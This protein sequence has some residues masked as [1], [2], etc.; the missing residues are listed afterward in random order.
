MLRTLKTKRAANAALL[1]QRG[2]VLA[3]RV[4]QHDGFVTV[5]TGRNDIDRR[6]N[7]LFDAL[8]VGA[9]GCRQ[10]FQGLGTQR[11]FAPARHLLVDRTQTQV[12]VGVSRCVDDRAFFVLVADADVDG[13]KTVKHVQLGQAQAR[14][15]VDFDG[16]TQDDGIEPAATT[17]ATGGSAELVA[18]LGQESTDIV[19]QLGRERTRTHTRG[20]GLG[21]AQNVIQ[22][23]RTKTRTGSDTASSGVGAGDVRISTV[24]D[25]Q[26]RTLGTFEHDVL[27]VATHF[28]QRSGDVEHQRL[29]QIGIFHAL[30]ECL[31]EV[32][33]RLFVVIDQHEVVVVE[34]LAQLGREAF[35]MEQVAN[36]QTATRNLVFV[37]RADTTTGGADLEFAAGFFTRLVQ[38]NMVRQ[39]QRAGRADA[40]TLTH[41]NAFLFQLDDF[42]QERVGSN[43]YTVT[44]QALHAFAQ[45]T[46]RNQVQYGFLTVDH[47]CVTS[48][49][50]T[51]IANY[52][53]SMFGQQINDL[54]FA[55][56]TP[57]SAQDYDILTHN[58]CPHSRKLGAGG[59]RQEYS[60]SQRH[61]L[62]VL[63]MLNQLPV[64]VGFTRGARLLPR[65]SLN[66]T[67]TFT[68]QLANHLPECRIRTVRHP[69]ATRR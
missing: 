55:L 54:A 17:S 47:Q 26:Q 53:G 14:D 16:A 20:V 19:E 21:D 45:Y 56:I 35:A 43:H 13:L 36:A 39:D 60:R 38:C 1:I 44:D 63:A 30:V 49:V 7:Q 66:H 51:L 27:A 50:A 28:M 29:E 58:T 59:G 18:T 3:E 22:V 2:E 48:V 57:L 6:A 65:Q 11:G 42:A 46:G 69:D 68:A 62:P 41:R 61:Y 23:H 64:T 40:Q 10:L 24:V 32:D 37:S 4:T 15:A 25:V 12:A 67:L 8:D 52:G 9:S 5:R 34:Q 31:L 33:G